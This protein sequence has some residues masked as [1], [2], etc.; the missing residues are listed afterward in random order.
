MY[1]IALVNMPFSTTHLPSIA[2]TQLKSVLHGQFGE[3][4]SVKIHYLNH[5]FARH[6]G[7]DRYAMIANSLQSTVT[8]LGDWLFRSAAFPD[9]ADNTEVYLARHMWQ[10]PREY[11][12]EI[13]E[14]VNGQRGQIASF[15]DELID[16]YALDRCSLVGFTSMFTQSV[17]SFAMARKLKQRNPALVTVMGGANCEM[18]MGKVIAKNV[19]AIDYVFS[20]PALKSFPQLVE[21]LVE[22]RGDECHKITGVFSKKKLAL[23]LVV[24]GNE[25]GQELDIDVEV[26]LDYDDYFA[27]YE[28]K[29]PS[30]TKA[31]V[32]H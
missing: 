22:G 26:P 4:V 21:H 31:G 25:I 13:G 29:C 24:G 16:R 8:G 2:L 9:A 1:E 15:L 17:A 12:D 18:S 3:R 30:G 5:D 27:S 6:M 28:D 11:N 19:E 10:F 23:E 32:A 14:L 7:L 20:G